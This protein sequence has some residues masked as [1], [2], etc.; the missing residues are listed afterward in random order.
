MEIVKGL[1]YAFVVADILHTG[2]L[3][4]L[5]EAKK[6]GNYLVVGILT[7]EAINY[8][9]KPVMPFEER[10]QIIE[11][12]K[13]VDLVVRQ[14]SR[15]PTPNLKILHPQYLVHGDDWKEIPGSDYIKSIG[16][17]AIKIPYFKYTRISSGEIKERI[18]NNQ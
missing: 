11:S 4:L 17:K 13:C 10:R 16:G 8:K 14:D 15:D 12:I 6:L 9:P 18:R 3:N 2:H 1:V 5:R 7:D